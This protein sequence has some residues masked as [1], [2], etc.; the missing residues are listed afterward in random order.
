[1][2]YASTW[3]AGPGGIA[4][5]NTW[6]IS[7]KTNAPLG[8]RTRGRVL[9]MYSGVPAQR[10]ARGTVL[11]HHQVELKRERLRAE[12]GAEVIADFLGGIWTDDKVRAVL[13]LVIP[14][15]KGEVDEDAIRLIPTTSEARKFVAAAR[16]QPKRVQMRVAKEI[17]ED[18]VEREGI[19]AAVARYA[20]VRTPARPPTEVF[21]EHL[22]EAAARARKLN[23]YLNEHLFPHKR[24][25]RQLV[26]L[27]A[28]I[29]AS[30]W[31][32]EVHSENAG[33]RD[34]SNWDSSFARL[35]RAE[36]SPP[37]KRIF[38]SWASRT[39]YW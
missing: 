23:G 13:E 14:V 36:Q 9:L 4:Y 33:K 22:A 30:A 32:Q 24:L 21:E 37:P 29:A 19:R 25:V 6:V 18:A 5:D 1:V 27:L 26:A 35:P 20:P 3:Q 2:R 28:A 11:K 17:Q 16:N 7:V 15:E 31:S 38:S 39:L 10:G 12:P 34:P 8:E